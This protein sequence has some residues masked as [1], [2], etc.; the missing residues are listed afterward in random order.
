MEKLMYL[1]RRVIRGEGP[2]DLRVGVDGVHV[3]RRSVSPL[4]NA[5][6]DLKYQR[7]TGKKDHFEL[8]KRKSKITSKAI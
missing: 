3:G 1:R 6:L 2:G 8:Q 4:E 5:V 7:Q